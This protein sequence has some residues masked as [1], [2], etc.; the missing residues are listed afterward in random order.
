MDKKTIIL[1]VLG[2]LITIPLLLYDIYL[3]GIAGVMFI[4]IVMSQMIMQDTTGIPDIVPTLME[5]A[6]GIVLTNTG[7]ARAEKIHAVLVPNNIEFD[8]PSLEV[9][10]CYEFPL[11]AMVQEI[12][13]VITWSNENGRQFSGSAKLSVFGEDPDLLKPMIPMF[14][15]KK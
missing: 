8:I 15:W 7:N 14:K 9:D 6:K 10:S 5:D 1:I 13:V 12:K 3:G 4:A 2:I 11:N